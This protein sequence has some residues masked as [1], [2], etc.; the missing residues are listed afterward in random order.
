[1][2]AEGS[3]NVYGRIK[4]I[5]CSL[6]ASLP[7]FI[8]QIR[9]IGKGSVLPISDFLFDVPARFLFNFIKDHLASSNTDSSTI[10]NGPLFYEAVSGHFRFCTSAAARMHNGTRGV[11][12]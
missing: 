12:T 5:K 3:K 7:S 6:F 11:H 4:I 9:E 8:F 2:F 1:M 10:F